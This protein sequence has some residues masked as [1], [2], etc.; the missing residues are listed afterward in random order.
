MRWAA[1]ARP[2]RSSR[3]RSVLATEDLGVNVLLVGARGHDRPAAPRRRPAVSSSS[4]AGEVV[5][6]D[7][8]PSGVRVEEGLVDRAL[9][10]AGPR[11]TRRHDGVGRQ[12]RRGDGGARC[13]AWAAS[14]VRRRPAIAVPIPVPGRD[15]ADPGRRRCQRRLLARVAAPVRGDGHR[16]RQGAPRHR[17]ADASASCRTARRPARATTCASRRRRCSPTCRGSSATSKAVTSC[18]RHRR[19]DR[20]R[21]LHRQRGAQDRRRRDPGHRPPGV[22]GPELHP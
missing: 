1:T 11:R 2:K 22:R 14:R 10:R 7:E 4:H 12:H 20:H 19:R 17:H 3:A 21:R 18:R 13:C 8:A 15:A 16:V 5:G 6:M 9:R